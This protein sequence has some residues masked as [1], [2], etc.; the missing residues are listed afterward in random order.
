V[1]IITPKQK[2]FFLI[3]KVAKDTMVK[4]NSVSMEL[5]IE[6]NCLFDEEVLE[7]SLSS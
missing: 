6:L 3:K 1:Q 2:H 7:S 5:V 4:M